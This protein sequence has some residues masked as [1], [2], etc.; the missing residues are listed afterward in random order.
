VGDGV[1]VVVGGGGGGGGVVVVVLGG[2]GGGGEG[3]RVRVV[4]GRGRERVVVG[5]GLAVVG[6]VVWAGGGTWGCGAGLGNDDGNGNGSRLVS[7]TG[8][9]SSCGTAA[10]QP[11]T[12]SATAA[13]PAANTTARWKRLCND[14]APLDGTSENA[15]RPRERYQAPLNE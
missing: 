12:L 14:P 11:N 13:A 9:G 8:E 10:T 2:G 4:V 3:G 6:S 1:V 5:T 7:T 15:L